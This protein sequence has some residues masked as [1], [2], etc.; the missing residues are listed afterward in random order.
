MKAS[1]QAIEYHLPE[2]VLS[3]QKLAASIPIGG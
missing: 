1:I 2:D 3:T